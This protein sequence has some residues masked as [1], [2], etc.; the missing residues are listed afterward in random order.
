MQEDDKL[1]PQPDRVGRQVS[2][3]IIGGRGSLHLQTG[4]GDCAGR[5]THIVYYIKNWIFS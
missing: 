4:A 3:V 5:S 1:W 2:H